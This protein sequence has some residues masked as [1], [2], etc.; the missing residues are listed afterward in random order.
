MNNWPDVYV[1]MH[2][3]YGM[4]IRGLAIMVNNDVLQTKFIGSN[5]YDDITASFTSNPFH[6]VIED[7]WMNT[8]ISYS[9]VQINSNTKILI[10][11]NEYTLLR[12]TW[13]S[14]VKPDNVTVEL[15]CEKVYEVS[16]SIT[17]YVVAAK[18]KSKTTWP[19]SVFN[20]IPMVVNRK[21]TN[22]GCSDS[23]TNQVLFDTWEFNH[24]GSVPSSWNESTRYSVTGSGSSLTI[25][26]QFTITG[27]PESFVSHWVDMGA[28]ALMGGDRAMLVPPE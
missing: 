12:C 21:T 11:D 8:G 9:D 6:I 14:T 25:N 7:V 1:R 2:M 27:L 10:N 18:C 19:K 20:R 23:P 15:D 26:D 13:T 28:K 3:N 16:S 4:Y 24:E 22:F 5:T 17:G